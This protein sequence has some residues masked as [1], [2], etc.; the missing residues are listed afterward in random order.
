[1]SAGKTESFR[2]KIVIEQLA[3]F[4]I[5]VY[6]KDVFYNSRPLL[7]PVFIPASTISILTHLMA[8][9]ALLCC[10]GNDS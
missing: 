4:R 8:H 9:F 6:H 1:M 5:V 10:R 2:R 7:L 3:K